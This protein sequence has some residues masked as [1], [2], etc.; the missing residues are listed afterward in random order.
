MAQM[1]VDIAEGM[2]YLAQH[3]VVHRDL[4]SRNCLVNGDMVVKI[5]DFG[6]TRDV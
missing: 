2:S 3:K 4:A 6:L 1:G 5:G